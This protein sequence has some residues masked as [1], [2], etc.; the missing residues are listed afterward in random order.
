MPLADETG[1]YYVFYAIRILDAC[2]QHLT[3]KQYEG[4]YQTYREAFSDL[5]ALHYIVVSKG[6]FGWS[7]AT[8]LFPG[9]YAH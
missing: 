4:I 5:T 3:R 9:H 8:T 1:A 2:K 7:T 6:I